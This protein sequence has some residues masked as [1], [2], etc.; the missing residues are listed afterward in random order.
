MK[1]MFLS[2]FAVAAL[3]FVGCTNDLTEDNLAGGATAGKPMISSLTANLTS[4]TRTSLESPE[5]GKSA[6]TVWSEGDVI[7]VVT[8]S[9]AVRQATLVKGAGTTSAAFDIQG[10]EGDVYTYAFY[11]Y[12]YN[13]NGKCVAS[14]VNG[15]PDTG[16]IEFNFPVVQFHK[17]GSVF[18]ENANTMVGAISGESVSLQSVMGALEIRLKGSQTVYGITLKNSNYKHKIS[19]TR[20]RRRFILHTRDKK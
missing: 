16:S 14:N 10:E 9:G 19:F 3:L 11:P 6:S 12:I 2:A 13:G 18:G 5:E 4:M 20:E 17:E 7:G 8:E 1:K 15:T